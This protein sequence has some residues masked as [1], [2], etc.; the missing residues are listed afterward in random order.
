MKSTLINNETPQMHRMSL[1]KRVFVTDCITGLGAAGVVGGVSH[2]K[3]FDWL[4]AEPHTPVSWSHSNLQVS[5]VEG[6]G[7]VLTGSYHTQLLVC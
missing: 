1:Q 2:R 7:H 3:P 4:P 5:E 6:N